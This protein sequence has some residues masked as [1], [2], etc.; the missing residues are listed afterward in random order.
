MVVEPNM[1]VMW[2]LRGPPGT[3]RQPAVVLAAAVMEIRA[4][5]LQTSHRPSPPSSLRLTPPCIERVTTTLITKSSNTTLGLV[6]SALVSHT[7]SQ[8]VNTCCSTLPHTS[9]L[10]SEHPCPH[11]HHKS[12]VKGQAPPSTNRLPFTRSLPRSPRLPRHSGFSLA[13]LSISDQWLRR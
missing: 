3:C 2:A 8:T 5:T 9:R 7:I 11:T 1:V 12:L 4:R 10:L 13:E 6:P